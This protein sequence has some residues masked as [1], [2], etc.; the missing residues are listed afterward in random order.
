[1]S[2]ETREAIERIEGKLDGVLER[3]AGF[4]D[5]MLA[6]LQEVQSGSV[7][8]PSILARLDALEKRPSCA[9]GD[10]GGKVAVVK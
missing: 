5:T 1:M 7:A 2:N 9:C 4:C 8:R 3:L 6:I 10:N